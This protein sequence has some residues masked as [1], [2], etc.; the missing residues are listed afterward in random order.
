MFLG[1]KLQVYSFAIDDKRP[2]ND[3]FLG[4]VL[5]TTISLAAAARKDATALAYWPV[6]PR[7][8]VMSAACIGVYTAARI[9]DDA[10]RLSLLQA[11]KDAV[12]M[13][14]GCKLP[15]RAANIMRFSCRRPSR[16]VLHSDRSSIPRHF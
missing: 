10:A 1:L 13:L 5:S 12:N 2:R 14:F 11:C 3:I 15:V 8:K 4:K 7:Y 9:Q 16:L 6:F